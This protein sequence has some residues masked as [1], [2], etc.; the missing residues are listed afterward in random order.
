MEPEELTFQLL[1]EITDGFSKERK[2]GEGAFGAVYRGVT[3]NGEDVAVKRLRDGNQDIE[4]RHAQFRNEF[5]NLTKVKH[6]NIVQFLGYCYE[7]EHTNIECDGKIVIVEK[8]HRALCFEYLHNGSLQNH[9]SDESCGLDWRTRYKII[10]GTCEG[11]KYI[12]KDLEESLL[13]LD[14]KPDN[15]LLDKNMVPKIADFGLSRIFGDELTR[16]TQSPLGTLGYQPPEYIDRGEISE[17][18]DIF[19]LGVVIIRIVSGLEGYSK[20]LDMPS[21]EFIDLVNRNWRKRWQATCSGG[22]LVEACCHQVETCTKMALNCLEKDSQN[23]PDIFMIINKLNEIETGINELP[24][25]RRKTGYGMTMHNHLKLT[26]EHKVITDQH[27]DSKSMISSRSNLITS[28][29]TKEISLDVREELIVGREMKKI[30]MATLLGSMPEKIIILPIYGIAGI[31]KTTFAK[32][33]YNDTNFKYYSQAWVYV[34]P[35]FDLDKIGKSIVSQLSEKENQ[36]DEI[37]HISSCLTKLLSGK[38]IMIVL[39]DLWENNTFQLEDLKAILNPGDSVKII[40]LVTTRSAH[41]A[42]KICCNIEPY[43][44]ESLTDKMC[45]DIIKRKGDFEAR[46]DKEKLVRIGKEIA[47]KCGGVALA[48]QTLGSMLQS[49]KY[50]QWVI[51]KDSDIWNETIS[52]DA[53]LPNHV[54][55]S[56]KLSY[57]SM[58]DCLKSCFTYCAIFPKGHKIVKYDLIYQWISLGFIKPTKIFSTSQLCEKYIAHLMGLSFL[59]HSVSPTNK[60]ANTAGSSCCYAL[61]ADCSKPLEWCTSSPARLSALHFLDCR[62]T[63]LHGAAFEPAESLRVLDL[64][65]CSIQ[66][67]PDSIG[68]LKQLRYLNA[69][70]IRDRMVPERITKLSNLR[71]LSLRGSCAILALPESIGEM[72]SLVHLDL[73]G[74]LGIER[75]PESFGNLK[76]LEHMD[77]TNCKNVTGVSQCL[78]R[79]TKLQ[80]LNLSNCKHIGRLPRELASLTELQYLNLSDSSYLSGNELDEAEYL[81]SLTKL[82]YLNLSSSNQPCIN[83]LP[84][85]LGRLT[86]LKYLNLSHHFTMKKLPASFGNLY[87]LV[88]LDLSG[89][90]L[91]QG[92]TAAL[93]GLTKLQYLDLYAYFSFHPKKGKKVLC[94]LSELRHLNL[95]CPIRS[96]SPSDQDKINGLLEWICTLTNLEYL[97]LCYNDDISSIPETIVNLRKLH[98]LDLTYCH[99]LQRLPASITEIESLKFLHTKGCRQLVLDKSTLPQHTSSSENS[100]YFVVHN[101]V[102]ESSRHPFRVE[103]GNHGRLKISRLESM[104]SAKEA[105][106]IKLVEKTNITRLALH[107]TRD[108]IRI[109][110]D[111]EVLRELEPP[112]SVSEFCLEGY[113]SVIF[114]SW[115]MR[116]G[117]Y[118]PGLASIDFSDLPS[119][120]NLP[121][122]GQLPNLE[123]LKMRRMDS[124]KK[125][126]ADL[127]GGTGAFPR[128]EHFRIDGMK[129][130]EEWN[131]AYSSD[132]DGFVFPCLNFVEIRH[133]PRLRFKPRLPPSIHDLR[134]D[135]SDEVMLSGGDAVAMGASTATRLYVECCVV[136]LHRWSLLRHLPCLER[137]TI[138]NCSDLTCSST[139]FP[140][141]LNSLKIL[142]VDGC[143]GVA[144]LAESLGDLTSLTELGVLNCRDIRTLPDTMSKLTCLQTLIVQGC[145]SITS[146]P[147]WL[148]DLTSLMELEIGN[149]RGIKTLPGTIQKLTHLQR[150]E[151]FGCPELIRWC[152]SG[153]NEMK[154]AHI[155]EKNFLPGLLSDEESGTYE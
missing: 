133:C 143:K 104:R 34:S 17:K 52:K 66:K 68:R 28:G 139:E 123:R 149:C 12:H 47:R 152:E 20:H 38:K 146:L 61:L 150:L 29:N 106:T 134:V 2:V 69:P 107:W 135:S 118:L 32:L 13:H 113:N 128:L 115:V 151:V 22:F 3:K 81:G 130:L 137:L 117:A 83:R 14:I 48:A 36:V 114:P 60:Q 127:Y 40:V 92:V 74:C 148:E 79:L 153:E 76:T 101:Y 1:R 86:E 71:Y 99:R 19:S 155:Q 73:S 4:Y 56:L 78:A 59:Q 24:Q 70:R 46:H 82:K 45:W 85:A 64:S 97:N 84:E 27:Q 110:D 80:Y 11:L 15:I 138:I 120:N 41:I 87:N 95:G 7:I 98:T 53:S 132:E 136:P 42:Q 39:D 10:K 72:E 62:R 96:M 124:I 31:G 129:C 6:K 37:Q 122:L 121:P 30:N 131:T 21:D 5:Y 65:K 154:L 100:P 35:T 77:F 109:V 18:F 49:M 58:D 140:Q 105:Q 55:A 75:L 51:V 108:A 67:L 145:E 112:Y 116:V 147:E 9:L 125:I 90:S 119:C 33:I 88:H 144:S 50:D 43:K 93:N 57:I 54:L 23:R 91:L 111:A 102:G 44:I 16:T 126:D 63:E 94:N 103:Y 141:G 8:I 26:K 25:K 142:T 89:C